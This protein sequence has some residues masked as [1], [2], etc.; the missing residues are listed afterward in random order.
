MFVRPF[1]DLDVPRTDTDFAV[2]FSVSCL[3]GA[4]AAKT[5]VLCCVHQSLFSFLFLFRTILP[6]H[7]SSTSTH[8]CR[9]HGTLLTSET[10]DATTEHGGK[11]ADDTVVQQ[12]DRLDGR[13][14]QEACHTVA[15]LSNGCIV[16]G[17]P[18]KK[19]SFIWRAYRCK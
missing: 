12:S 3:L 11:G 1:V 17:N 4:L 15:L 10:G 8:H 18:V 16:F 5:T 2:S 7:C 9:L 13:Q 19:W 14:I 6:S